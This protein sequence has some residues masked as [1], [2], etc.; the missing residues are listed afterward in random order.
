MKKTTIILI[1][2]ILISIGA[3]FLMRWSSPATDV[4][5]DTTVP[6]DTNATS[7]PT[8]MEN[9][10]ESVIG[11]SVE[12]RDIT[13]YRFG[14]GEKEV[15]FVGGVHGGYS[16]NAA[17]VAYEL[18]D[19]LTANPSAVPQN[20]AVTV[21]PVLN[22]DG[23]YK[24]AGTAGHFTKADVTA[25]EDTKVSARFN[26][27]S[28]D[29]NRNFDCD[30]QA[31][32]TWQST[33]V[34]G[35]SKAFSEPETIALRNYVEARK[36]T[37]VVVWYSAVG[38][39]FS[40]SCGDGISP[41]TTTITNLYAK[42]SGYPSYKTFDYYQVTGDMVNWFAKNNIPAISV[43]LTNH[44]DTE[45]AKNQKGIDALLEHYAQ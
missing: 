22:P 42:A 9:K 33:T 37:A 25:S 13:A 15:L 7:T 17:L 18:M 12:G 3:Y 34:S 35:G 21:I 5:T 6:G 39:V 27:N 1:V 2:I 36:P 10:G 38:G 30:W 19:Y 23:L 40:S 11:K 43:L 24:V 44:E 32:A 28:V 41:E 4:P 29:L 45:W 26:A 8:G 20:V 14:T 31:K 16:W